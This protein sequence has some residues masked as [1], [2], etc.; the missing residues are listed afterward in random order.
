MCGWIQSYPY[1]VL[2]WRT[3]TQ[4]KGCHKNK[5]TKVHK[6]KMLWYSRGIIKL[7]PIFWGGIKLDANVWVNFQGISSVGNIMIPVKANLSK[8]VC[9]CYPKY[10]QTFQVPKIELRNAYISCMDTAY[11]RETPP[12]K[13]PN[14]RYRIPP[15]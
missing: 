2:S 14:I 4:V 7:P 8:Y 15:F 3:D 12:L 11:V 10:H 1:A 13:Q 5:D 6:K 9:G